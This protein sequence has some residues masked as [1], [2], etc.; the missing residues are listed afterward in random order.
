MSVEELRRLQQAAAPVLVLDV[1]SESNFE[2]SPLQAQGA[3]RIPPDHVVRRI[4]ELNVPRQTWIGA[5]CA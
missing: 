1:R 2:S 4:T 5:F 3:L